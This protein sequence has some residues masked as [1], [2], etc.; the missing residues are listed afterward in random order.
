MAQRSSDREAIE[1][2][3]DRIRS[4]GLDDLRTLWRTTFR[5]SPPKG[6]TKDLVAR[7]ICWHIQEQAFGGL[8]PQTDKALDG[9]ARNSKPPDRRL[10]AG[11]V[12]VREYQGE[13]HTVTVVP[14]GYVWR[15]NTY[16]SLST[17]ARAITGTAWNGPRFF[18]LR[19]RRDKSVVPAKHGEVAYR[20]EVHVA[21]H[22]PILDRDLFE[23][24]QAK[25][26]ANAV[27]RKARLR[28][29]ASILTGRIYDILTG[30]IYDDR[31]NRM[32]PTH[33][34]KLGVR[35]RYYVSHALLQSRKGGAGSVAR[36]PAPEIEQLVLDGVRRHVE[37]MGLPGAAADRDLVEGHVDRVIV[38]P[39]AVEGPHHV[40][41]LNRANASRR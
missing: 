34:N 30:R 10:K 7:F 15:E 24:V 27:A 28:G 37:T 8:D 36:G 2:E 3:I 19:T 9:Y 22:E 26:A 6:F 38:R 13:R 25:L 39:Q 5:S 33:S 29:S 17:I 18:G 16:A 12:L 23:S 4:L 41:R 35:Y 40:E 32:S 31:G 21:E 14:G 1:A 11:T 20:G